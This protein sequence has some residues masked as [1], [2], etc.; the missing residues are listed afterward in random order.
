MENLRFPELHQE[1]SA[2]KD[3]SLTKPLS[4]EDSNFFCENYKT[5]LTMLEIIN[6]ATENKISHIIITICESIIK[7]VATQICEPA[8]SK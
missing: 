4:V 7:G 2:G 1:I 8:E 6:I 3:G 5:F